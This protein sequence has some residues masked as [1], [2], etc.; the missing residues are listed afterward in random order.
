MLTIGAQLVP[1]AIP[2][3][4]PWDLFSRNWYLFENIQLY[5]I[6]LYKIYLANSHLLTKDSHPVSKY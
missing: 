4:L 6:L 3:E 5:E 2:T 1:M